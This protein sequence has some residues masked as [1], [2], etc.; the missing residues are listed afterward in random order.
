MMLTLRRAA[1]SKRLALGLLLA[2]ALLWLVGLIV[3]P[4][5]E[6][7]VLSLR[8]RTAPR[9][10]EASLAQ[11]RTFFEEPL[12]WHTFVRTALMAIVATTLTLLL[13]FPIA[14]TISKLAR[15]RAKS[16]LFVL[17][18]I[19]FWV[20][21][22]VRTLGWMILLRE[23]GV[24]PQLLVAIGLTAQPVELLYRDATILVGLVYT[25]L[26][27]MVVPLIGALESLDDAL[28]EAAYDLGGNGWSILRQIVIPH[29]AP[30]IT[31]G[32]IVV[33]M[34]T[35]GNYLTP[36]LLGG[37]NSLWF[38]EQIYTQFITRFNWEQGAAFG[39]LLLALSTAIVWLGLKLAGQSFGEA[40]RRT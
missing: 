5:L 33:F 15:G 17:C 8:A 22:T 30:G 6:L 10:Y 37:K 11:Y 4:H 12:Y 26:L 2:P 34:L 35:L 38:T 23:S 27:F 7:G 19:P 36:T 13:A 31:A 16:L 28:V 40:M 9:Q 24:L 25:S 3:L 29:A 18:L 39:F 1:A 20:S 21:E 32:C 14:W